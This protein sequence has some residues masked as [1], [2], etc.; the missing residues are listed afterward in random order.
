MVSA[1]PGVLTAFQEVEDQ[2]A[3]QVLLAN[4]LDEEK[5]A[6]VSAR[7]TLD[8]SNNRYKA[9]VEAYL[10][11]ITA[12]AITLTHE[13]TVI[14]LNA[15]RRT[16]SVAL[17]KSLGGGWQADGEGDSQKLATRSNTK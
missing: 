9:G 12:Q 5:S 13:Q 17:I 7:R 2:L 4:Q 15:Q 6:L 14:Q 10:D 8:I 16:A 3:A 1:P 11:V